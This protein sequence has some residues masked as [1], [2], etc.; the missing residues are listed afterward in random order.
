MNTKLLQETAVGVIVGIVVGVATALGSSYVQLTVLDQ[1][2]GQIERTVERLAVERDNV[3]RLE[4]RLDALA[5]RVDAC[6][7]EGRP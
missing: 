1:R 3:I 7:R 5:R 2:L 4:V 6:E